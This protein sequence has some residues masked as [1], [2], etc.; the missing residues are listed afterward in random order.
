MQQGTGSQAC[1]WGAVFCGMV[2]PREEKC[3]WFHRL[4]PPPSSSA[5]SV[6]S[7]TVCVSSSTGTRRTGSGWWTP[8]SCWP[9][10]R[11]FWWWWH[12]CLCHW[13]TGY[14]PVKRKKWMSKLETTARNC[15]NFST[16]SGLLAALMNRQRLHTKESFRSEIALPI[17]WLTSGKHREKTSGFI[18]KSFVLYL[19]V[20]DHASVTA[21][22]EINQ[23]SD[24][25]QR[26]GRYEDHQKRWNIAH[27]PPTWIHLCRA[28]FTWLCL[29]TKRVPILDPIWQHAAQLQQA[30]QS[31][32]LRSITKP[33]L[34]E[35]TQ[36]PILLDL[37]GFRQKFN[38]QSA[39]V[40]STKRRNGRTNC[41]RATLSFLHRLC[42]GVFWGQ[43][44][45]EAVR[46]AFNRFQPELP[47][48][49]L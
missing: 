19:G 43:W 40:A 45:N 14:F 7:P 36:V 46:S 22:A 39:S 37:F 4:L 47:G 31:C 16:C 18:D 6:P 49:A 11:T 33:V 15:Q 29:Q 13:G 28:V 42:C 21:D 35:N 20:E 9:R 24:H 44:F 5:P 1:P 34:A 27:F 41:T 48:F 3:T 10:W 12:R 25:H 23:H 8:A 26:Y 30:L 32:L 2:E 17:S 38:V